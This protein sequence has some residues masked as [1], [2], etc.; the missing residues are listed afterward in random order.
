MERPY[1]TYTDF[2]K[3]LN[4]AALADKVNDGS[5]IPLAVCTRVERLTLTNCQ[6]L[7]DLGL[8]PLVKSNQHLLA[9]DISGDINVTEKSIIAIAENCRR[10]QG[11]NV[12][13]CK[14]ISNESLIQLAE[15]CRFIKRVSCFSFLFPS[16]P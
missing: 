4:L 14:Q 8:I 16:F 12:S 1:F 2:V 10:L 6:G 11:L 15:S 13:N 7:T 3:R 5:V 9:L